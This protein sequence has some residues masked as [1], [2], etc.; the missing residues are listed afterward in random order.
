MSQQSTQETGQKRASFAGLVIAFAVL[1]LI[2][3]VILVL[4]ALSAI[5]DQKTLMTPAAVAGT[6]VFAPEV[7]ARVAAADP[8]KGAELFTRYACNACHS[9]DNSAGPNVAG[10]GKRAATRRPHYSAAAYL[11]ESITSPNA[12]V[13]PDYPAGVMLQNFKQ[14]I[15]ETDLY[16]LI[17]WLLLQ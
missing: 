16:N 6:P 4:V 5:P 8:S 7:E 12:F 3:S 13:V 10:L 1:L 9:A 2:T 15:P 17:A 11:Y 14:A